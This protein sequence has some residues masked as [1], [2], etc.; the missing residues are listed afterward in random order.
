MLSVSIAYLLQEELLQQT[1]YLSVQIRPANLAHGC[2][3]AA[4][5]CF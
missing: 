1:K 3:L 5:G 2:T 4:A